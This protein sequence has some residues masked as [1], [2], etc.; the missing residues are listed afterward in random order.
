MTRAFVIEIG[1][2]NEIVADPFS[3]TPLVPYARIS[4]INIANNKV[5]DTNIVVP[6]TSIGEYLDRSLLRKST[7][8]ANPNAE[9]I[10]SKSPIP[11]GPIEYVVDFVV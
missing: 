11:I 1:L 2:S 4:I 9:I 8:R 10:A 3:K 6:A 7:P 5:P